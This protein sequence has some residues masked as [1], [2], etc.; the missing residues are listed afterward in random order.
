MKLIA[1]TSWHHEGDYKFMQELTEKLINISRADIIKVHLTLNLDEYMDKNHKL[2]NTLSKWM[3]S[4]NEWVTIIDKIYKSKKK[5]MIL[6]NDTDSIHFGMKYNPELVEIHS[7]CL[8]DIHLLK[9]LKSNIEKKTKV[10][11]G[12]GGS[13]IYEIENTLNVLSHKNTILM[14]GFQNYPTHYEDIN[15]KK[16]KKIMN[17]FPEFEYGYA[18]HTECNEPN[19]ILITLFGAA[20]G[21]NYIEKH[22]TTKFGIERCDW[23]SAIS[24]E[25]LNELSEKLKILKT[26]F[27]NGKLEFNEAEKKY[28]ASGVM[29]KAAFARQDISSGKILTT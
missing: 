17:L 6:F 1:E 3:L 2:Y 26:C 20:L 11:V 10:V 19:N 21:M 5:L 23:N 25:M 16:I 27:G 18:D 15:F 13:T 14:F 8:N 4:Q 29:K 12:I 28:S 7:A 9:A 24:I 22:V